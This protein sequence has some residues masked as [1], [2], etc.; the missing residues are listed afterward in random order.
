MRLITFHDGK[1]LTDDASCVG[2]EAAARQGFTTGLPQ[3][4]ALAPAGA[5]ARGAIHE[6]LANPG[7]EPP[8]F[9]AMLLAIGGMS[10]MGGPPMSLPYSAT[11]APVQTPPDEAKGGGQGGMRLQGAAGARMPPS[12][13]PRDVSSGPAQHKP[14]DHSGGI[15][16]RP[17]SSSGPPSHSSAVFW[18]DPAAELYPPALAAYGFPLDRLILLRPA[19]EGAMRAMRAMREKDWIWAM[20][21]AL[22]CRGVGAVVAAPPRL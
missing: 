4:D 15:F 6:L 13:P 16:I 3:L 10:G 12:S 8:L 21:E 14:D 11:L 17:A 20:A 9:L 19:H 2:P 5:F 18:C 22:G 1:L 7:D